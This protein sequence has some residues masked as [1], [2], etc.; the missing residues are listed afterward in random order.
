M[1][2]RYFRLVLVS[3][4][5]SCLVHLHSYKATL[6]LHDNCNRLPSADHFLLHLSALGPPMAYTRSS[7][8]CS[9]CTLAGSDKPWLASLRQLIT[10]CQTSN[11]WSHTLG[12]AVRRL[13][14]SVASCSCIPWFLSGCTAGVIGVPLSAVIFGYP[15]ACQLS[16][17]QTSEAS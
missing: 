1:P 10:A 16:S 5:V 3:S 4:L 17:K 15:R 12:L 9:G 14:Y 8:R 11:C 6:C 13:P 7:S 2:L